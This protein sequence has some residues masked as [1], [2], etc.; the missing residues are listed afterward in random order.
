MPLY[1]TI[2]FSPNTKILLWKIEEEFDDMFDAVVLTDANM[3]RL[4]SMKSKQHQLGFMSVRRLLQECGYD[5]HDLYYDE[6]GKPHLKDGLHI[7]ITHSHE[8]SAIILTDENTGIDMELRRAKIALL[9]DKF[10]EYELDYLNPDDI[11]DYV[12]RLTVI[13][14]IKESIFKIRNEQGISFKDHIK[15]LKF[16]MGDTECRAWLHFGEII[17]DYNVYFEELENYTLVYAFEN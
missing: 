3:V 16:G 8:F 6:F 14:G 15:V 7:S 10:C 2:A 1:K 9:A 4:F 13:W 12:R 11:E 17:K 5:D